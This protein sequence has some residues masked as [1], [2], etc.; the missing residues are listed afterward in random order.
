MPRVRYAQPDEDLTGKRMI[1]RY[2]P[3][4]LVCP[5]CGKIQGT[6]HV[7]EDHLVTVLRRHHNIGCAFCGKSLGILDGFWSVQKDG[8]GTV[9]IPYTLLS[10]IDEDDDAKTD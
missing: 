1:C 9:A 5:H 7:P 2:Q 3:I 10:H 6:D 4:E 8:A